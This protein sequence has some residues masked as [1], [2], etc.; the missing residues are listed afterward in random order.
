MARTRVVTRT[1]EVTKVDAL[2]CD[3]TNINDIK[4][5]VHQ[6]DLVSVQTTETEKLLKICKKTCETDTIK[7]VSIISSEVKEEIYG[8]LETDFLKYAK[9]MT[10]HRKFEEEEEE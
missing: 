4:N 2:V 3:I 8:M 9:P 7:V 6:F 5:E 1:I 10:E